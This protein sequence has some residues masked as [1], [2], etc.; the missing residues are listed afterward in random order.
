M[1]NARDGEPAKSWIYRYMLRGRAREMGLGS[2]SAFGLSEA[3]AR[4][5][6]AR[7][8]LHDDIDPI[9]SRKA[10]RAHGALVAAKA[11][12]SKECAE[13]YMATHKVAWRNAKHAAQWESTLATYANPIIGKLPVQDVDTGLVL[14]VLEQ[15]VRIGSDKSAHLWSAKIEPQEGLEAA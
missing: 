4:A 15:E 10:Q 13:K 1:W 5:T 7:Q 3:R 2:L 6:A 8:L 11:I 14:T 12:T 9:E